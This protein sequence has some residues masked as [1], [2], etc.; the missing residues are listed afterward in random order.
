M[1]DAIQTVT[2]MMCS[3]NCSGMCIYTYIHIR[4]TFFT[5]IIFF[6]NYYFLHGL[7][8]FKIFDIYHNCIWVAC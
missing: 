2:L 8:A 7:K 4:F 1:A 5:R 6:Y 3:Y